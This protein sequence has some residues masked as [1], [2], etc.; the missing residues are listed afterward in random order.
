MS[1]ILLDIQNILDLA[2]TNS[3]DALEGF[4]AIASLN[5]LFP[6]EAS[7][8]RASEIQEKLHHDVTQIQTEIDSL[9]AEL[10]KDQEPARMQLIQELIAELLAQMSRIREKAT[11]SEAIVR[12]ITKDIQVLD[13]AKRNLALSVTALKRFQMLVNA[14]GQL[15]SM[16]KEKQYKEIAQTLGAV[17][18]ISLFFKPYSS[19]E[20]ISIATRRL[21]ELQGSVRAS[22]EKDF[23]DFFLQDPSRPVKQSTIGEACLVVDVLGDNVRN[24][25]L[26]RYASLE[27]KEY[28]R[29]FRNTDEAGQLDN[30]SRRFAYFRRVLQAH[31]TERARAFPQSWKVGEHLTACFASATR[32]DLVVGLEAA[33]EKASSIGMAFSL[34]VLPFKEFELIYGVCVGGGGAKKGLALGSLSRKTEEPENKAGVPVLTV[35]LLVESLAQTREFENAMA[36]KFGVS[37]KELVEGVPL[38]GGTGQTLSSAFG[39][40][41]S[42]FVDAQDKLIS[43]LLASHRGTN[44]RSSLDATTTPSDPDT[45]APS[46]LPSSTELFFA[47]GTGMDECLKLGGEGVMKL[48]CA[49]YK[50]WLKV[51]AEDVLVAGTKKSGQERKSIDTRFN[52]SEIQKLCI[53]EEK[54]RDKITEDE[55]EEEEGEFSMAEEQE[56][57]VSVIST[58]L[59]LLLRELDNTTDP[60]FQTLLKFNWG[61]IDTVTGPSAW[62]EELGT[63]TASVSQV[64]HDKIEPKKYVRS[65]CDRASNALVTRFTNALVKSRPIKGLGGEQ[66]LL[67]LQS[68]K[69]SLLK[70]PG[71]GASTESM[72]ARNVTKNISRLETLLKV[73][74]TPVVSARDDEAWITHLIQRYQGSAGCVC[75]KL[76]LLIGDS[77]F[78]NFQKVLDLKGT[79]KAEQN[80]LLDT[81]LTITSTRTEL[82][83]ESF[84]TTLDMDPG[85]TSA[86]STTEADAPR[87]TETRREVFSDLRKLV[88]FTMRRERDKTVSG[89]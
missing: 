63:A 45:P 4:D 85:S 64:I 80:T 88:S 51:Y 40:H 71:S 77:S 75:T 31:D 9:R 72:Y 36:K 41:M 68:F 54:I 81:L 43:D 67:D 82:G 25:I 12:D 58:C 32:G 73:I 29:I 34:S 21:Q 13:L 7:L 74:I 8:V 84:L 76:Y 55:G 47:I 50:K 22:V 23:D 33:A 44:A 2:P 79:P 14:L 1:G 60:S 6:D 5:E 69:S 56:L 78:S 39:K 20:R 46:L 59:T 19:I 89:T 83:S 35:S 42:V 15:E 86:S 24:A 49:M 70:I 48:M 17:K 3:V 30:L 57:F 16:V 53:L 18:E 62:V 61:S 37:F 38:P 10:R 11:E 27:L 52:P 66:L 87:T 26:D 28:R 65:F